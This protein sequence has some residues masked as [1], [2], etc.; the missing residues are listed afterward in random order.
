M[1]SS[2]FLMTS[3]MGKGNVVLIVRMKMKDSS[4]VYYTE[5]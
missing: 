3:I 4:I 2:V 5:T 1:L